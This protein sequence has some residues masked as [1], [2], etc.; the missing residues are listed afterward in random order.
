MNS[1]LKIALGVIA[2]ILV[3]IAWSAPF[4]VDE[5]E[6]ALVLQFG[7]PRR[8]VKEPGLHFKLPLLQDVVYFDSRLL[9]YDNPGEEVIASD[10]KRLV[11]D[12]F[13]RYHITDPLLFYQTVRN[14]L[15]LRPR[16]GSIIN[17]NLRRTLGTV[18]LEAVVSDQRSELMARI[19]KNV[20]NE[21]RSFGIQVE[22]VRIRRADLPTENSEAIYRRMQTERQQ[23]AAELR[24]QGA[25]QAQKI[26]A[27]ADRLRVV[28]V[29]E[30]ERDSEILRGEG[31]AQMNKIFADAFGKDPDFFSFYRTMQAYKE[32]LVNEDTTMVLSPD[33][34]FFQY[35]RD[36]QGAPSGVVPAAPRRSVAPAPP[37]A[38]GTEEAQ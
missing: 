7:E 6:Q 27:E 9:D 3:I 13:S 30:A 31:E 1:A 29:A 24:A 15:A 36:V 18:P 33:S 12:A 19:S 5:R 35:F 8:V 32:A 16:L 17:S 28:I 26:R 20:Q 14:E 11:V 22:D 21:A 4:T 37:A 25:E 34:D 38:T 2:V 23:E 10:Q